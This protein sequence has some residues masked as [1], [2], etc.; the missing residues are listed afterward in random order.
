MLFIV[1]CGRALIGYFPQFAGDVS[2]LERAG[3]K[4]ANHLLLL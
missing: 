2:V 3:V 1:Y 4:A